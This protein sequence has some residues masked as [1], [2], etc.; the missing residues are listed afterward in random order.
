MSE[1]FAELLEESLSS[2][3]M[4][5]GAVIEA[6]VVDINGDYVIVNAG[7][8][9]ESEIP[10]SQFRDSEGAVQVNIGDRVEVAIET[11]EDGYGNTR[12]SR[13]RARRAKSWEVLESAFADQSIV[14]G[15]LTGKVK[16]GF[17]VSMDEVRAFL[18]GSLVDVR[19]VTDTVFLENKELE[20]K[21]I[22][23]DRVRNNVVVS[24][25][26]V[27]EKE[28]EAER[29][30]LLQ[31][32][33]EGQIMKGTVKNLT[34]YGAFV[35]LGGLDGLLH[36]TDIAWKRVKHPSDVLEVGQELDVRVLKFDRER[37]RVSLGLKQLGE[38]PW[39]DI[40]RRYP[41]STRIFGKITNI[42]D[43]GVFVELEEGVEGLVHVSEMDWTNKNVHPS[44][45]CHLGD[46]V[47][48]K[49]LEIDSER[50]RISLGIKQCTP[51]PWEEFAATHNK[52]DRITGQ[53][54]SITDFGVFI[55]LDGGIDGLIHLSDLSWDRP[56]EDITREFK[57]GDEITAVVLAV[58]PDRERISLGI[59]Q[60]QEDPF[61]AYVSANPKGSVVKGVVDTID[62]KGAVIRLE[63][64]VE[65]YLRAADLSRDFVEDARN[66]LQSGAEI[67]ARVTSIER[68]SRRITLSVKALEMEIEGKAIEEYTTR[69]STTI[70]LGDKLKEELS[71]RES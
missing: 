48:V 70:S 4:K 22:K 27:V 71:K 29:V 53:I 28:M 67:E 45:V 54:R 43:Y 42:T 13:E 19:P 7:L 23:L 33:E 15:F 39:A 40:A 16:G 58:D 31:N 2:S 1:S 34:D 11:V 49:V 50:R 60:A 37:N 68:K 18:P 32:L 56:G 66:A 62:V 36:I 51:N 44:K 6:E 65:G 3:E 21:V 38:D 64:G 69:P 24:R 30:E 61:G 12:L 57:K 17:T 41:E 35:N 59:K 26:A 8:K 20:F 47:E 10:A 55:G 63:E 46:E 52:N 9:S 25:R 14:K 5:P